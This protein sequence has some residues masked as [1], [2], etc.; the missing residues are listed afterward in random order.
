MSMLAQ[1]VACNVSPANLIR[2]DRHRLAP[3]GPYAFPAPPCDA[4]QGHL[5]LMRQRLHGY[6]M[7]RLVNGLNESK[8]SSSSS[9]LV[10]GYLCSSPSC[11]LCSAKF[12]TSSRG[13]WCYTSR[14]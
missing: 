8:M 2:V 11:L 9:R 3:E 14:M 10:F 13:G 5:R 6:L 1:S 12:G 4:S 7:R